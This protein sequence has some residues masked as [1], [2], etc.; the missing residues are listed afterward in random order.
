[1]YAAGRGGP[2]DY[3]AARKMYKLYCIKQKINVERNL[4]E[5][6]HSYLK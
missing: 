6:E 5:F 3:D 1:M 2:K 4:K